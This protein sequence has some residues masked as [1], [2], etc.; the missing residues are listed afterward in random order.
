MTEASNTQGAELGER[1]LEALL[2]RHAG[3]P[4]E[5]LCDELVR[6][7]SEFMAGTPQRDDMTLIVGRVR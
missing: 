6:E 1:G 5:Q 2:V 3:L 4:A 7:L